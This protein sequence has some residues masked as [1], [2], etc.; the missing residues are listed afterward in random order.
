MFLTQSLDAELTKKIEYTRSRCDGITW[1]VIYKLIQR[2]VKKAENK[3]V[4]T[5]RKKLCDLTRNRSL[6]FQTED[7]TTNLSDY[8][9]NTEEV[10]L[11]K[12]GL[13]FS[14]PPKFIKK[15]D[16][17]CQFDMIAKFLTKHIEENEVSAQLKSELTRLANCYIYK[18]TPSKS[19][20]KKHKILQK[21]RSQN[22]I[23][24]THP[25]KGNGIVILNR[26]DYIRSMMGLTSD[27]KEF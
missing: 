25:D 3:I 27:K 24:I 17:S 13:N 22:D 1:C 16:V 5:H 9:L 21:L 12:N 20:L 8:R 26:S 7:I 2:N 23:I 10:D 11:L 14:I 6:P 15:T 19:S 4:E 18:N